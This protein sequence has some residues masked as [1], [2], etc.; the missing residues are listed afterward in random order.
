MFRG[1]AL[2]L[3]LLP[4]PA[5]AEALASLDQLAG[6]DVVILGEIHDNPS[7][8]LWQAE[9]LAALSPAAVVFEML[10]A[11]QAARITPALRD[12][13]LALAGEIGWAETGWPDFALYQPVFEAI[14]DAEIRGAA[15][16]YED[17]RGA[18]TEGAAAR[19]SGDAVAYG[20]DRTLPADQQALREEIQAEAHCDALPPD[21]LPGMVEAQRLRDAG[22]AAAVLEALEETGGPVVLITGNGHARIDWA[23]PW[24]I[25]RVAPDL[26]VLSVAQ[27]EAEPAP[28]A[29][30]D[31]WRVTAPAERDDPCGVFHGE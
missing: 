21:L 11:D 7:H 24:M 2:S 27:V 17:V 19:F 15:L 31:F 20:L 3:S 12:D 23:V 9:A 1:L 4:G 13:P 6:A 8:H 14:G 16:P 29:P 18:V 28:D 5:V 26:T 25:A 30:F 10:T 22:F